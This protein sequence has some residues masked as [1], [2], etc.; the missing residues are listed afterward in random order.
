MFTERRLI[1]RQPL[2]YIS[3]GKT[4]YKT[5]AVFVGPADKIVCHPHVEDAIGTVGQKI[6]ESSC[7]AEILQDVDG[8]DKPGH[9]D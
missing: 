1:S 8:R 7:H 9:D 6:N 2:Q 3:L 4:V 5:A